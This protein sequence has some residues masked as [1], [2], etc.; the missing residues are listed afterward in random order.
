MGEDNQI[1]KARGILTTKE[2]IAGIKS[3]LALSAFL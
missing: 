2:K 1:M 3:K